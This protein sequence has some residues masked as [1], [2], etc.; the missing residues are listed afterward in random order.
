MR[1]R[2]CGTTTS[3]DRK[4]LGPLY[5]HA[6]DVQIFA[7]TLIGRICPTTPTGRTRARTRNN[8]PHA[9]SSRYSD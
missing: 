6:V 5:A 4:L 7:H 2:V 1:G 3:K 8:V 9:H